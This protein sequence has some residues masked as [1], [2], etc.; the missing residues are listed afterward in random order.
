MKAE[1][2][3]RLSTVLATDVV[4]FSALMQR[5]EEDTIV[6]LKRL[7]KIVREQAERHGARII[8]WS[9]DG[10]LAEFTSPVSAV[11]GA[12]EL[13][14]ELAAPHNAQQIGLQLRI[15]IHLADV[16]A[17][18]EDL[19]GDGVNIAS[20]IEA[21]AEPG[22]VL[23]SQT[24]F[25]QAKRGA[26]VRFKKLGPRQLKNI[27]EPVELYSVEGDLGIHSCML[28]QET[29][30]TQS[31]AHSQRDDGVVVVPFQ[32]RSADAEQ[33]YFA[34]GFTEDLITELSRFK[35]L[36]VISRNASFS[37]AKRDAPSEQICKDTGVR[38]SIEGGVRVLGARVRISASLIDGINKEQVWS[39]KYDC[40]VN[41]LFDVQDD[42][43]AKIAAAVAGRVERQAEES[44][45]AK[46]TEDMA[47][48]DCL[49][50]GLHH[51]RMG[52]V[53]RDNAEEAMGWLEKALEK[54]PNF[55]RAQAWLACAVATRD[56]W[57]GVNDV[58]HYWSMGRRALELDSDDA[59]VHRIMGSLALYKEDFDSALYHFS[60]A[61]E[62]TPNH[63]YIVA[64][65]GNVHNYMGDGETGLE[66]QRRAQELD[67]FLP[68]YC[69]EVG[70]IAHYVLGDWEACYSAATAFPRITRRAAAY[71]AAA[72]LHLDDD[73]RLE[74]ATRR[75]ATV[76]PEFDADG[77]LSVERF[78][79]AWRNE[80]LKDDMYRVRALM[81]GSDLRAVV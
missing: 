38:Y 35:E 80:K 37:L 24:V 74:R 73:V 3:R 48:Y 13:Q 2:E 49:K 44:A 29:A 39:E 43:V 65:A 45:R 68:E 11:R 55:G 7:R 16:I 57:L 4:G 46:P 23:V 63:A 9:G 60:R 14:R 20:R 41:D 25:E 36:F 1:M 71:R 22:G 21:E 61:L 59:E 62:I 81:H 79:E 18:G 52:G 5:A 15:G 30:L 42:M 26:Q 66:F 53:T 8:S 56:E 17:D 27:D 10:A 75:L 69:R 40:D 51:H 31:A 33:D 78:Q 19:L 34:E 72:A 47:A 28:A 6:R 58:D 70:V 32:N 76:D 77:L 50:R 54:D 67:P 12:F 64:H